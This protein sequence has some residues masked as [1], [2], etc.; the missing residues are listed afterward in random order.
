MG[1]QHLQ[2]SEMMWSFKEQRYVPADEYWDI[3][4]DCRLVYD[5]S[6]VSDLDDQTQRTERT[7]CP[8]DVWE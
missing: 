7:S 8:G 6:I 4:G 5:D 3:D 1:E 2:E